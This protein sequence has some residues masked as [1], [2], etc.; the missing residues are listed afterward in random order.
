MTANQS[1]LGELVVLNIFKA[2]AL[3]QFHKLRYT[4]YYRKI[5][6]RMFVAGF[7]PVGVW[8]LFTI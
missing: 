5:S 2:Y 3:D 8:L 6:A 4:Y 7:V 1:F